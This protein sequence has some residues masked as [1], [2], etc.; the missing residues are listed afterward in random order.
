MEMIQAYP[1]DRV[2]TLLFLKNFE[3]NG[4]KF[5][6]EYRSML[7]DVPF[8]KVQVWIVDGGQNFVITGDDGTVMYRVPL[9]F[10]QKILKG[11]SVSEVSEQEV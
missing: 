10:I 3:Q 1:I 4:D 6:V 11:E 7:N 9:F 5:F 2:G 8:Q